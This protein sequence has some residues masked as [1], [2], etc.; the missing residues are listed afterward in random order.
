MILIIVC[1]YREYLGNYFGVGLLVEGV[2][3]CLEEIG[4]GLGREI[5][6]VG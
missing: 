3:E 6:G 4:V 2:G 5:N 1:Y